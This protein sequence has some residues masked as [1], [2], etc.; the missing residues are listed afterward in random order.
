MYVFRHQHGR[1]CHVSAFASH[2][3]LIDPIITRR[4]LRK[5]KLFQLPVS[6]ATLGMIKSPLEEYRQNQDPVQIGSLVQPY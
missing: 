2:G 5:P 3:R 6:D 1:S 4:G